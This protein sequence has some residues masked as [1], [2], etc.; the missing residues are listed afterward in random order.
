MARARRGLF[1]KL[2]R[3]FYSRLD[4]MADTRLSSRLRRSRHTLAKAVIETLEP[5]ILLSVVMNTNDHGSGSLRAAILTANAAG[6]NQTITFDSN[7]SGH[8]ITLTTGALYLNDPNG[9][10]TIDGG[11]VI[12]ISGANGD[13]GPFDDLQN[14]GTAILTGLTLTDGNAISSG[15]AISNSGTLSILDSTISNSE[16]DGSGGAIFSDGVLNIFNS[17][18]SGSNAGIGGAVAEY[19]TT[20]SIVNSTISGNSSGTGAIYAGSSSSVTITDSTIAGN[21]SEALS[22]GIDAGDGA[23]VNINGSIVAKNTNGGTEAD[24]DHYASDGGGGTPGALSGTYNLIGDNSSGLSTSTL[25]HNH[26]GT[27]SSSPINPEL[28]PLGYYGGPTETMPLLPGSEA[29]GA[30]STFE[31]S[32][33]PIATDQRGFARPTTA[34]IDIG[35]FQTQSSSALLVNTVQDNPSGSGSSFGMLSLRD[36]INLADPLGGNQTINFAPSLTAETSA[37]ISL[38]GTELSLDDTSGTLTIGGPGAALLTITADNLSRVFSVEYGSNAQIANLTISGGNASGGGGVQNDGVLALV[39][40]TISGNEASGGGGGIASYGSYGTEYATLNVN[41]C[42]ISGNQSYPGYGGGVISAY[43]VVTIS[44]SK[45]AYNSATQGGGIMGRNEGNVPFTVTNSTIINNTASLRGGGAYFAASSIDNSGLDLLNACTISGNTSSSKGGGIYSNYYNTVNVIESTINGNISGSVGG[46]IAS[47]GTLNVTNSTIAQ[48]AASTGGGIYNVFLEGGSTTIVDSTVVQNSATSAGGG[49]D[50]FDTTLDGSIVAENIANTHSDVFGSISGTY[51]LIGDGGGGLSSSPSSHNQLGSSTSPI[52]P[53]LAPLAFNGGPTQTMAL[54]PGS[55]ASINPGY[56]SASIK[57]DQRGFARRDTSSSSIGAFQGGANP[58]VT[59]SSLAIPTAVAGTPLTI[60]STATL[61]NDSD[62]ISYNWTL[63]DPNG[64]ITEPDNPS[65]VYNFTPTVAGQ[66]QVYLT[67]VDSTASASAT[68]SASFNVV[69]EPP[70]AISGPTLLQ[71]GEPFTYTA[72]GTLADS[73]AWSVTLNGTALPITFTGSIFDFTPTA[74]GSYEIQATATD[75]SGTH[76][77]S[78]E[79]SVPYSPPVVTIE[80]SATD[81]IGNSIVFG[82]EVSQTPGITDDL[83]YHWALLNGDGS[84]HETSSNDALP[85]FVVPGSLALGSYEVT[86]TVTDGDS[87]ATQ[88]FFSFSVTPDPSPSNL[89]WT[90]IPGELGIY[91]RSDATIQLPDGNIIISG[92]SNASWG[93]EANYPFIA[94]L[95]PDLTLDTS[96]GPSQTGIVTVPFASATDGNGLP[97]EAVAEIHALAFNPTNDDIVV[98]GDAMP[99][100]DDIPDTNLAVAE[101]AD[102]DRIDETTGQIVLSGAPDPDFNGGNV[103]T[104]FDPNGRTESS[105]QSVLVSSTTGSIFVGGMIGTIST[106]TDSSDNLYVVDDFLLLKLQPN[107]ALD[108][109]FN[110]TGFAVQPDVTLEPSQVPFDTAEDAASIPIEYPLDRAY[111]AITSLEFVPDSDGQILAGGYASRVSPGGDGPAPFINGDLGFMLVRYDAGGSLDG[112]FGSGGETF[113]SGFVFNDGSFGYATLGGMDIL[114]DGNILTAGGANGAVVIAEYHANGVLDEDYG[115]G[116]FVRTSLEDWSDFDPSGYQLFITNADPITWP[117]GGGF[118][119]DTDGDVFAS[120]VN[121]VNSGWTLAEFIGDD[122]D[123][124]DDGLPVNS[125]GFEGQLDLNVSIP[126]SPTFGS[127]SVGYTY[128]LS[129]GNTPGSVLFTSQ[130]II[131]TGWLFQGTNIDDGDEGN[132]VYSPGTIPAI[133]RYST[134]PSP[135]ADNLTATAGP[136]Q[137]VALTWNN[138]GFGQNGY[139]IRRSLSPI[140][141]DSPG[142][143]IADVGATQTDYLDTNVSADTLYYYQVVPF[144]GNSSGETEYGS[145]TDPVSVNTF[146]TAAENILSETVTV[147]I[148]GSTVTSSTTL[149][150]GQTYLLVASGALD[151]ETGYAADAAYW[152]S[153]DNSK[154]FGSEI[155]G[156]QYGIGINDASM[157][158]GANI[159]PVWGSFDPSEHIYTYAIVGQGVPLT[160]QFHDADDESDTSESDSPLEVQIFAP[161]G[162]GASSPSDTAPVMTIVSPTTSNGGVVPVI[163][164]NTPINILSFNPDGAAAPRRSGSSHLPKPERSLPMATATS[165]WEICQ[166]MEPPLPR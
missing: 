114:P 131:A 4:R 159:V 107:G 27:S 128:P 143:V 90:T 109:T 56:A 98:V 145:A 146:P 136:T 153:T 139:E 19:G 11:G 63:V 106:N 157:S 59:V 14:A 1:G 75:G 5:R 102:S 142:T 77:P 82:S 10:L 152:Y 17:T 23:T 54:L 111:A 137:S 67:I 104:L 38:S 6:E 105:G 26:L 2:F 80:G 65:A 15:G 20:M 9:T 89:G 83:A 127:P 133:V 120:V 37:T 30:G 91:M 93:F 47:A 69:P 108:T 84:P 41:G 113:T 21:T 150:S 94:Q 70:L 132:D 76:S 125:F 117:R 140:T 134:A 141:A 97:S 78:I 52:N 101:Y 99:D 154:I 79:A 96:F 22:A 126:D 33:S 48:N 46:G 43:S 130:G 164:T 87:S 155:T 116:G 72:T 25:S 110:T 121:H 124:S 55:P 166:T 53:L 119:F 24:V 68:T 135:S 39:D 28:A 16:S 73:A 160:F 60:S 122:G 44:N 161:P 34:I 115:T 149:L 13:N 123:S 32:G 100:Y 158:P 64:T 58:I 118:S 144:Y 165:P 147:P 95:N 112:T 151:I 62:S 61:Q 12:T 66:W 8:T 31:V 51:N 74:L 138:D 103:F 7:L 162:S 88:K 92:Y 3:G 129:A 42:T 57:T 81:F 40:C 163:S 29:I 45:I 148:N 50:A 49:I 35:A 85:T 18:I 36:A 86:L 71:I 156:V